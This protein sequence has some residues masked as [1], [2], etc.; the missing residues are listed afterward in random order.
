[1]IRLR[2]EE[3][4]LAEQTAELHGER[5]RR[6]PGGEQRG[7][8]DERG[9][10]E[11]PFN[12]AQRS[13]R[14]AVKELARV[15][16]AAHGA[17]RLLRDARVLDADGAREARARLEARVARERGNAAGGGEQ[18]GQDGSGCIG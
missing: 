15:E 12:V 16:R 8:D 11:Q 7:R 4:A 18:R 2:E 3:P 5:R 10:E 13:R 17:L 14:A 1:M 9:D 6:Q